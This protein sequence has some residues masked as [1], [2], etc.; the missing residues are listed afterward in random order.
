[1]VKAKKAKGQTPTEVMAPRIVMDTNES[2]PL[3]YV[4]HMEVANTAVDFTLICTRLPAKLSEEKL[5]ELKTNK[6]L[7]VDAEVQVVIPVS[8]VP[9][10]IKALITQKESY[11]KII[12]QKIQEPQLVTEAG[13]TGH[14]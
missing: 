14:E 2:T 10:I 7:H 3:Y 8:L 9:A 12:G 5:E 4:N 13:S 6:T 11:E 1:M